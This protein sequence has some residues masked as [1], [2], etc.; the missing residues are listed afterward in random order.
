MK[1][2]EKADKTREKNRFLLY[3][4]EAWYNTPKTNKHIRTYFILG[5]YPEVNKS[6]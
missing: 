3:L 2:M 5:E 1:K 4:L 6:Q